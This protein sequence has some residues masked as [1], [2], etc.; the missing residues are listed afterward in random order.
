MEIQLTD[1]SFLDFGGFMDRDIHAYAMRRE[2]LCW[3]DVPVHVGTL[4]QFIA[5]ACGS[6][7]CVFLYL[8]SVPELLPVGIISLFEI[9]DV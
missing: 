7:Q 3:I 4:Y 2:V 6:R 8:A 9:T 1:E 5:S